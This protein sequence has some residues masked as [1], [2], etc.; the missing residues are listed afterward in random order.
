MLD[1]V[2][3]DKVNDW[4]NDF[5]RYM[6]TARPDVGQTIAETYDFTSEVDEKL[7]QSIVDFNRGWTA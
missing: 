3:V 6:D 1:E 7:Q 4:S 2:P 5:L